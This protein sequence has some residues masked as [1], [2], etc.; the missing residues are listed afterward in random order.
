MSVG[1]AF[2]VVLPSGQQTVVSRVVKGQQQTQSQMQLLP[3]QAGKSG[4]SMTVRGK[5]VLDA[6][7]VTTGSSDLARDHGASVWVSI[8]ASPAVEF[9]GGY[10][11]SVPFDL[12][13]VSFGVGVS[14]GKLF[15]TGE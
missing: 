15:R 14:V 12:N 6:T 10:T 5:P 4:Q 1:G 2:Y 9:Y 13:T 8:A 11:R 3:A 7:P